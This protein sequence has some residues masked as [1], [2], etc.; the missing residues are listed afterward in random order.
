MSVITL[1]YSKYNNSQIKCSGYHPPHHRIAQKWTRAIF[2]TSRKHLIFNILFIT[3]VGAAKNRRR[4]YVKTDIHFFH[5][6]HRLNASR[7]NLFFW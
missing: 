5:C 1:T 7:P 4:N 3:G 2:E 6:R